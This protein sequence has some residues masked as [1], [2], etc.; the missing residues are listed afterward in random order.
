MK[1]S[2]FMGP[3][4]YSEF[5]AGHIPGSQAVNDEPAPDSDA[6]CCTFTESVT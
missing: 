3:P 1:K 4:T 2:G 5:S 6:N